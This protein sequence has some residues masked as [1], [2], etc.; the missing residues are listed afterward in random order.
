MGLQQE[1]SSETP[2]SAEGPESFFHSPAPA[3]NE[4]KE[5][6][7]P[8]RPDEADDIVHQHLD[9]HTLSAALLTSERAVLRDVAPPLLRFEDCPDQ[10]LPVL[11]SAQPQG[12]SRV[13][14]PIERAPLPLPVW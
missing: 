14:A 9:A 4:R 2:L 10:H 8:V 7:K 6:F 11:E 3:G 12:A 1:S 5:A 13:P